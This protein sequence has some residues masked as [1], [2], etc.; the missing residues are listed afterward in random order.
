[1]SVLKVLRQR[2][3]QLLTVVGLVVA[4]SQ[5]A[6]LAAVPTWG[7]PELSSIPGE[8][9]EPN[10]EF[11]DVDCFDGS[12]TAVGMFAH[13]DGFFHAFMQSTNDDGTQWQTP[14]TV[15]IAHSYLVDVECPG[16]GSRACTAVGS[17]ENPDST[18][19]GYTEWPLA[20]TMSQGE[21]G[22]PH[23]FPFFDLPLGPNTPPDPTD[24][25][26]AEHLDGQLEE[27][28]C[29]S[30]GNCI[31]VGTVSAEFRLDGDGSRWL[32]DRRAVYAQMVNGIWG[33]LEIVGFLNLR[34]PEDADDVD[35]DGLPDDDGV[36]D[37]LE[38]VDCWDVGDCVAGGWFL[39]GDGGYTPFTMTLTDGA[40]SDPVPV[41]FAPGVAASDANMDGAVEAVSCVRADD[42]AD[43][44]IAGYFYNSS[45]KQTA[46]TQRLFGGIWANAV[47]LG[48]LATA[49]TSTFLDIS[50]S[51][52]GYCT[53][54]GWGGKTDNTYFPMTRTSTN[55]S[56][57]P[58][59]AV[60]FPES[61]VPQALADSNISVKAVSC[62]DQ[63]DCTVAGVF[64]LDGV[65]GFVQ[66]LSNGE[67]SNADVNFD[68]I[69]AGS[70]QTQDLGP[71]TGKFASVSC[72]R[73]GKCAAVGYFYDYDAEVSRAGAV[74]S[75]APE[76]P[77]DPGD[78]GGPGDSG[79]P[80]YDD[81]QL[82]SDAVTSLP[83]TGVDSAE[84]ILV[85]LSWSLVGLCLVGLGRRR[86]RRIS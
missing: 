26:S 35:N 15:D 64:R 23:Q 80:N 58:A 4:V 69:A 31:A 67:W 72:D 41:T 62:R 43:C 68:F 29:W 2:R 85:A 18:N 74:L 39:N 52:P 24:A 47:P 59:V 44:T 60:T 7:S 82:P 86:R 66:T 51:D 75:T 34:D 84:V 37:Y 48:E 27:S 46:F 76:D 70:V 45:G 22:A 16:A 78:P 56:W 6:V 81:Y 33:D 10:S 20:I 28:S 17:S 19:D 54:G 63:G 83:D 1:M 9:D 3:L 25:R 65:R 36:D 79:T 42:Q 71:W 73:P 11:R 14:V 53:A 49:V 55:G 5:T 38:A 8:V 12:C 30:P 21:W 32:G 77:G 40:W 50:C 13:S 57:D 61:V